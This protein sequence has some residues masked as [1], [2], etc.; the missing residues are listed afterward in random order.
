MRV[1]IMQ[2][3]YLPWCGYFGLMHSIDIFIFLDSVQFNRRGWQQRNRIK[4][5]IGPQLLTVPVISKGKRN[6]LISDVEI[7]LSAALAGKHLRVV[8]VNYS[9]STCFPDI[10]PEIQKMLKTPGEKLAELDL[11]LILCLKEMLN[12]G[13][14]VMRSS[15]LQGQGLKA[16]LL[17]S[18]CEQVGATEYF[19]PPGSRE[20]LEASDAFRNIGIP[21]HYF[22]FAHPEYPQLHGEFLPYMSC[23]EMLMN[24][25]EQTLPLI[26]GGCSTLRNAAQRP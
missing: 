18:L 22:D 11:E 19:S 24:C 3:L 17:A 8:E 9:K 25:G 26:Q 2:P 13:T 21:V 14:A 12:L 4:T 1:A 16:E 20:Y 7:N 10:F 5:L 15:E 23:I 6:Q